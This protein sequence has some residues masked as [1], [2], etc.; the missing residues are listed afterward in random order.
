MLV[1]ILLLVGLSLF[2]ARPPEVLP[3]SAPPGEFS[4]TRAMEYVQAIAER[5]HPVGTPAH[6]AVRSYTLGEIERLGLQPETQKTTSVSGK[7]GPPHPAAA[8]ENV[9]AR[10]E[11]SGN[12]KAV[13][14]M[15][16]YDS[17]P[18]SPGASDDAHSVALLLETLRA[19]KTGPPLMNDVIFL[20]TDAEE[21]GLLGAKA[22]VE[23]HPWAQDVGVVLNF[24]ARGTSGP[25]IMFETSPENG[26]LIRAFA[27][28]APYPLASS[29]SAAVYELL[30]NDTDLTIFIEAGYSGLNFAYIENLPYYHTWMDN[31][32]QLDRRSLQHQ[33]SNALSLTRHYGNADLEQRVGTHQV[34]F[35]PLGYFLI[36]YPAA[37]VIPLAVAAAIL[38]I[39]ILWLGLRKGLL[40]LWGLFSSFLIF[41]I[42]LGCVAL[43]GLLL[44]WL[45]LSYLDRYAALYASDFFF[46]GFISVTTALFV[47][48][49]GRL[50]RTGVCNLWSGALFC[51]LLLTLVTSFLLPG[52]SYLFAWPLISGLLG[53]AAMIV[54]NEEFSQ[55]PKAPAWLVLFAV[56]GLVLISPTIDNLYTAMTLA[57]APGL[58]LLTGLLLGML[59]P[60][61]VVLAKGSRWWLPTALLLTAAAFTAAGFM[62]SGFDAERRKPNSI[63]YLLDA[64]EEK[65]Y[66]GSLDEA[67]D[68]WTSQFFSTPPESVPLDELLP[69]WSGQFI[70]TPAATAELPAPRLEVQERRRNG[71]QRVLKSR[72][73]SPRG[74]PNCMVFLN[75]DV[76]VTRAAVNGKHIDRPDEASLRSVQRS[77]GNGYSG[78]GLLYAGVPGEGFI[79]TLEMNS[80]LPPEITVIDQSFDLPNLPN[81]FVRSRPSYMMPAQQ[82]ADSTLV[83]AKY[84]IQ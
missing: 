29:L 63:F 37:W 49:Y 18:T 22:F 5:P 26:W 35:N 11:G 24:E 66:W 2:A 44:W 21:L 12:G 73:T 36:Y 62:N 27:A 72:I 59:I 64:D 80:E 41:L 68:E 78:W 61:L 20:I 48:L 83:R 23:E 53:L 8:I 69:V 58:M 74:A 10:L 75:S 52:G 81:L 79:L 71:D 50:G 47:T 33:G 65:S 56:P 43:L 84:V 9:M 6:R 14:L 38:M 32:E 46:I 19:L 45:V 13:L 54:V 57:L 51:W 4:A 70:R 3:S 82:L 40:S 34:Y 28:A 60:Q 16:H 1:F 25:S 67:P 76:E 55:D 7:W 15:G 30:P 39:G 31:V 77:D 42:S 17:V